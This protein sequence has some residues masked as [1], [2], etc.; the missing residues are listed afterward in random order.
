MKLLL[1]RADFF[2]DIYRLVSMYT[3]SVD[4][5]MVSLYCVIHLLYSLIV[6]CQLPLF[7]ID[8]KLWIKLDCYCMGCS[9]NLLNIVV[10]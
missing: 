8:G 5:Y 3:W 9:N 6:A 1:L 7:L 10:V 4:Q 2:P